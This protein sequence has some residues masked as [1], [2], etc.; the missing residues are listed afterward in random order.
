MTSPE[1][2]GIAG[3]VISTVGWVVTY[4]ST[5]K[6]QQRNYLDQARNEAR[7]EVT[8][9]IRSCQEWLASCAAELVLLS[10]ALK[11]ERTKQPQDWGARQAKFFELSMSSSRFRWVLA[12]EDCE[13]LFPKTKK[14]REEL[15]VLS[16]SIRDCLVSIGMELVA[17][18]TR[19]E[20]AIA[21]SSERKEVILDQSF[22]LDDLR[23]Y[24]QNNSLGHITGYH[25]PERKPLKT[26][27]PRLVEDD[28]G[29]LVIRPQQEI[30][31]ACA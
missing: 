16:R 1:W 19:R 3:L 25:I 2:P 24:L 28:T 26:S 12:L 29:M 4:L 22:M 8:K 31:E 6:A 30:T 11:M 14:C 21:G 5:V 23:S 27:Y 20:V 13:A 9:E 15:L 18:Q 7:L 10:T 17:D